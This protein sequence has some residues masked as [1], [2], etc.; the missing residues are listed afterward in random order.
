M[1]YLERMN[2]VNVLNNNKTSGTYK[3]S[4]IVHMTF[5]KTVTR[6]TMTVLNY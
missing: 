2:L 1:L 5:I 4:Q 3:L 6:Y